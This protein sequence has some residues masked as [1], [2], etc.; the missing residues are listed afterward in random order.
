MHQ[1]KLYAPYTFLGAA[2][3]TRDPRY[4]VL[5]EPVQ[6]GPLTARNRFYQVPHCNGMGI[7]YPRTQAAMRETKAEGGWAVV[8]T[9][10][11]MFHPTSETR[12]NPCAELMDDG[13]IPPMA[14]IA[15]SIKGHGALAGVELVHHGLATSNRLSREAPLGPS[16]MPNLYDYNDPVQA[17]AMDLKDIREFRRWHRQAALRARQAGFD[18]IYVYAAHNVSLPF[19]FLSRRYNLRNDEYGGSLENRARLLRELIEDTKEA[20]GDTCAVAVRLG[21]EELLGPAGITRDAEGHDLVEMLAELPDLWDVNVSDWDNDSATS[22]FCT[23]GFQETHVSFVKSLTSKP[24]VGVGWFTSPDT[25]VD[26]IRR[27]VLDFIGAARPSI[28]DPFLP[29]KVEEGRPEDIRECI[30]CNI[31]ISG[32]YNG[33]PMRCTQ[34]PTVGEE[35]RRNWHP[36]RIEPKGSEARILVVGAGPAGLEATLALARRGY[37]V[38]LAEATEELGG[39]V[40]QESSLPGLAAWRRVRD[41]RVNQIRQMSE[42]AIYPGSRMTPEDV[43]Q[44]GAQHVVVA[45]GARWR[46]DGVGR[47]NL[48]PIPGSNLAHVYTAN[49]IMDGTAFEGPVIVF[50]DDLFY[51]GGVI[52]EALRRR[53]LE[54]CLVTPAGEASPWTRNTLEQHR[55]QTR[56]IEIG[57]GIVPHRNLARILDDEVELACT[58]VGSVERRAARSIV[59]VTSRVSE[60]SIYAELSSDPRSLEDA[61]IV[62]LNAIGDAHVPGTIAAAVWSGHRY[63]RELDAP[64]NRDVPY[65]RERVAL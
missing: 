2:N 53:G 36:E 7:A 13:D 46:H 23:E 24:V 57:V 51:M 64:P 4:D 42:A 29:K 60:T 25:M 15:E 38:T 30:G 12:P 10:E 1:S 8:C 65:L 58:F 34:N 63:A 14:L 50:D 21:V 45:T 37:R 17:R 55:I 48:S 35:W 54:T 9:E 11:C 43:R 33:V 62:S 6:I 32:S 28:A 40:V 31:C 39:R 61:G 20:V 18:I 3:V 22:R 16:A 47:N 27:G 49:D 5:F 44:F 52:A 19:H 41:Y 56:L 26:Q 59:L